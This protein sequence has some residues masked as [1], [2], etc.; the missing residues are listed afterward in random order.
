MA[1]SASF[2]IIFLPQNCGC[3]IFLYRFKVWP[4]LDPVTQFNP[5]YIS[6]SP[7]HLSWSNINFVQ[8]SVIFKVCLEKGS[9]FLEF[10]PALY[11]YQHQCQHQ[12]PR[13]R[14]DGI[15]AKVSGRKVLTNVG[16][17]NRAGQ[18]DSAYMRFRE[19][20]PILHKFYAVSYKH[21]VRMAKLAALPMKPADPKNL[22][23]S[24]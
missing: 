11:Q 16:I 1:N 12:R 22:S 5:S 24:A 9:Y 23:I 8:G 2:C 15:R 18:V 14:F 10:S 3:G 21:T 20:L 13:T 17:N 7:I 6:I 4:F 19:I